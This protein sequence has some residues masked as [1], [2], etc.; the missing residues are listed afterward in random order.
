MTGTYTC[1]YDA[2]NRLVEVKDAQE[3][4]VAQYRY[5]GLG[6]RIRKYTPDGQDWTV[7]EFYYNAASQLLEVRKAGN[8]SRSGTPPPEPAVASTIH[9]QY[10]WSARYIDA[11]VLR[12]RDVDAGGDLGK[13]G[14]G[15]DER[16]YYLTDVNMNVTALVNTSGAVVERYAYDPYGRVTILDGTTDSQTEW[17][18]DDDQASD[19]DNAIL[20][21][22]YWRDAE[23]HL[24]HV[25]RRTYHPLLGRWLQRDPLG[26]VDGMSLYELSLIHISEPTRPY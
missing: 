6:R 11:P 16:L 15:L 9:E 21:C 17:A 14:S 18:E 5:D 24:Y 2:W 8:V 3:N 4:Y 13:N 26:Y 10:V 25:R 12:D 23:T 20:Y 1:T 7:E 19:V 22:G